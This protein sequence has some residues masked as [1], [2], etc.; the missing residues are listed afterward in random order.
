MANP[1]RRRPG[2]FFDGLFC[3]STQPAVLRLASFS[4]LPARVAWICLK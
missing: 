4:A 2:S 3:R 1:W